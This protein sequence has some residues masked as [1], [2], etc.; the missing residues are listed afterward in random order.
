[1]VKRYGDQAEV[2]SARRADELWEDG[3]DAGV[4]VWRR[5][6]LQSGSSLTQHLP[7]PCTEWRTAAWASINSAAAVDTDSM[8]VVVDSSASPASGS[9]LVGSIVWRCCLLTGP[10]EAHNSVEERSWG[11]AGKLAAADNTDSSSADRGNRGIGHISRGRRRHWQA[12]AQRTKC[13]CR[14]P[15]RRERLSRDASAARFS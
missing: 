6:M 5:V 12:P 1:M 3:D 8:E 7:D 15:P 13:P 14:E 2:E 9:A 11:P 10:L 4:A